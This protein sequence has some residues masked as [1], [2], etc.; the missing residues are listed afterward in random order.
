MCLLVIKYLMLLVLF[1]CFIDK[2][3]PVPV[4]KKPPRKHVKGM[5][6][7]FGMKTFAS[8]FAKRTLGKIVL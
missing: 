6:R 8:V 7:N 5:R 1:R 4:V 3:A 2:L